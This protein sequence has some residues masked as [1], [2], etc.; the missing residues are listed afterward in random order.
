[1]ERAV[2]KKM[3][4][5]WEYRESCQKG[6]MKAIARRIERRRLRDFVQTGRVGK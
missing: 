4:T 3:V 1:M 5:G 2:Y 6:P